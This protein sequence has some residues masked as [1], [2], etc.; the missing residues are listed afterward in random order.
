MAWLRRSLVPPPDARGVPVD[1]PGKLS[2]GEPK[3]NPERVKFPDHRIGLRDLA[4]GALVLRPVLRVSH[5]LSSAPLTQA[6]IEY[7]FHGHPP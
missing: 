4:R 5:A 6:D 7:V 1:S 3:V 2:L